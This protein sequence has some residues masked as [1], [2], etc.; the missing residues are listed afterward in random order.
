MNWN[1]IS[2][3]CQRSDQGH[4]VSAAKTP[5]GWRYVAWSPIESPEMNRFDWLDQGQVRY[6]LG[7]PIRQRSRM[8][9]VFES[10]AAARAFCESAA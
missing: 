3:H 1:R 5:E 8:L 9:G 10:A 6:A 7:E 4:T 2:D